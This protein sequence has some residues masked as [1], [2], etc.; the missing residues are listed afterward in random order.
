MLFAFRN[1][2]LGD[3]FKASYLISIQMLIFI[4]L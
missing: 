3:Y 1:N 2:N 4:L